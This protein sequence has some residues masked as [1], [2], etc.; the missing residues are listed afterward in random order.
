[1]C[2]IFNPGFNEESE[3]SSIVS[4]KLRV[5][6]PRISINKKTVKNSI[7]EWL[8]ELLSS[9]KNI[10]ILAKNSLGVIE[11][12][13]VDLRMREMTEEEKISMSHYA[14]LTKKILHAKGILNVSFYFFFFFCWFSCSF[15][16]LLNDPIFFL[17][18]NQLYSEIDAMG[19]GKGVSTPNWLVKTKTTLEIPVKRL[20]TLRAE[21]E[22]KWWSEWL[23]LNQPESENTVNKGGVEKE[24]K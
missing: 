11:K 10:E 6:M 24:K 2:E 14:T 20:E 1:M 23:A 15:S 22:P 3:V 16:L 8:E 19:I 13:D 21:V 12:G 7:S 18:F 5:S 4:N 9:S 17:L